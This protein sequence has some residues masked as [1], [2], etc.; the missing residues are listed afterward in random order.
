MFISYAQNFEDVMLWRALK[1][2][3]GGFYVDV[4]AQD[5]IVDSVS[6]AFYQHG[7]RGVHIEPVPAYANRLRD[8]RPDE[9]VIQALV[10]STNGVTPFFEVSE[11]GLS[12]TNRDTAIRHT[13]AGFLVQETFVPCVPLSEALSPFLGREIHWLKIDV[14]GSERQVIE[15]WGSDLKPW[16]VV[17]ESTVPLSQVESHQ[18]WEPLI[19]SLGYNFAYFDGLNRFF[20]SSEHPELLGAFRYGPTI[21]DAFS[22]SGSSTSPFCTTLNA[23]LEVVRGHNRVV[24]EELEG[25]KHRTREVL[26]TLADQEAKL[27]ASLARV[28]ALEGDLVQWRGQ[29]NAL[30]EGLTIVRRYAAN[31]EARLADAHDRIRVLD[32][33]LAS[34]ERRLGIAAQELIASQGR[35]LQLETAGNAAKTEFLELQRQRDHWGTLAERWHADLQALH[36]SR[37]LRLTAPLRSA[38]A[39]SEKAARTLGLGVTTLV[40]LPR[41]VLRGALLA[42]LTYVDRRPKAKA[43]VAHLLRGLPSIL[44][45]LTTFAWTNRNRA[46]TGSSARDNISGASTGSEDDVHWELYPASVRNIYRELMR[47][48]SDTRARTATDR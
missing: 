12:T 34:A 44:D 46:V 1:G 4:G 10:G 42:C 2:V 17:V 7:W 24:R 14:E 41:H 27:T 21:F 20:V 16:V 39:F 38:R 47:V 48:R 13:E 40:R 45:T 9:V 3:E 26:R 29:V 30:H 25:E 11:T 31:V 35:S 43:Q 5:P 32:D 6:L 19:L 28:E 18:R 15:G 23:E 37:S 22:L 36:R 33:N 8:L